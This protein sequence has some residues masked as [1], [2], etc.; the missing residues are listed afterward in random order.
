MV[1]PDVTPV[2]STRA[3]LARSALRLD[4]TLGSGFYGNLISSQFATPDPLAVQATLADLKNAGAKAVAMEVSSHGLAQHRI[5][6]VKVAV[7]VLTNLTRDHL[8]YHGS[9]QAYAE[10]KARL[11]SWPDI[12]GKSLEFG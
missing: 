1:K 3:R 2:I 4:G 11:F 7:A 10:T 6:A 5:A 8:D 9:M 12:T